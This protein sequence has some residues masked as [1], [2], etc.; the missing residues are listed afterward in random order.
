[1]IRTM[2]GLLIRIFRHGLVRPYSAKAKEFKI[3]SPLFNAI[4]TDELRTL[5][6]VFE[7]NKF[8][9]KIAGGAVRDLLMEIKPADVDLATNAK[10]DEM[11]KMFDAENIRVLNLKGLKH[12]TVPVRINDKVCHQS[13]LFFI[14]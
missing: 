1:M 9:L 6:R 14:V 8:E 4:L 12:G 5:F 7:K 3:E 11:L 13:S 2:K 10:P